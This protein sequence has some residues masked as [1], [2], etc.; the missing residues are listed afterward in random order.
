M[1]GRSMAHSW[2][3][4]GGVG[5]GG[6]GVSGCMGIGGAALGGTIGRDV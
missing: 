5:S 3:G 6:G 4:G 2:C 1:L